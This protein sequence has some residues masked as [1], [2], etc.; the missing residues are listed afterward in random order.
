MKSHLKFYALIILLICVGCSTSK[1]GSS[2]KNI[3][4][5]TGQNLASYLSTIPRL[6]VRGSGNNV[7]VVNRTSSKAIQRRDLR[8]LFVLDGIQVGRNFRRVLQLINNHQE[9]EVRFYKMSRAS[10]LYGDKG[11]NGAVFIDRKN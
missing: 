9:L 3:S 5:I 1:N 10:V 11:R 8:P 4:K 6:Q 7:E 2:S